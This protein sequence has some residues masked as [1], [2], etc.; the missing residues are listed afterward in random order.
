MKL[1]YELPEAE[2]EIFEGAKGKSERLMY[3]L[4]FNI[5]GKQFVNDGYMV[6]TDA[7]KYKILGKT[8]VEK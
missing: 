4:P 8:L 7:Y 3:C 6:F 5:D 2:K 1:L